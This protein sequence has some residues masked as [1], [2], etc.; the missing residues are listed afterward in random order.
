MTLF[1]R[2]GLA[3]IGWICTLIAMRFCKLDKNEM[4]NVQKRIA[5]KKAAL[6]AAK[7]D[8]ATLVEEAVESE[9]DIHA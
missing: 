8:E 9:E 6:G 3:I 4:V 2:F 5:E 7:P 1:L